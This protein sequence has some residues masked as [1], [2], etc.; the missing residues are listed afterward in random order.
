MVMFGEILHVMHER[1]LRLERLA[2][3]RLAGSEQ[4]DSDSSDQDSTDSGESREESSVQEWELKALENDKQQL[5]KWLRYFD[6]AKTEEQESMSKKLEETTIEN[7]TPYIDYMKVIPAQNKNIEVWLGNNTDNREI[8]HYKSCMLNRVLFSRAT[9]KGFFPFLGFDISDFS[10]QNT[11]HSQEDVINRTFLAGDGGMINLHSHTI[12]ALFIQNHLISLQNPSMEFHVLCHGFH[13]SIENWEWGW[14]WGWDEYTRKFEDHQSSNH[15]YFAAALLDSEALKKIRSR[16]F[17][18]DL[19]RICIWLQTRSHVCM[20]CWDEY[21]ERKQSRHFFHVCDNMDT[22]YSYLEF[23]DFKEGFEDALM[24]REIVQDSTELYWGF[25]PLHQPDMIMDEDFL[26]VSFMTRYTLILSMFEGFFVDAGIWRSFR[27]KI[28]DLKMIY[29]QF[30]IDIFEFI[31]EMTNKGNIVL[32]TPE[33]DAKF[34]NINSMSLVVMGKHGICAS[35]HYAGVEK[36]FT[37]RK[38]KDVRPSCVVSEQFNEDA[39]QQLS[40]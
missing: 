24:E 36:K 17:S 27:G 30:E 5:K 25:G 4:W 20:L 2:V 12:P 22:R 18:K 3:T 8:K 10:D 28:G 38:I 9:L 33:L 40:F 1:V 31:T 32:F 11:T 14:E 34:M 13:F 7:T 21:R 37:T 35:Y 19:R 23:E 39:L 6:M 15:R 29:R 16:T 26:C